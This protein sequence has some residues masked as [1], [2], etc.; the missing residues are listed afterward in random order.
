MSVRR[1]EVAVV[2]GGLV[3]AS[4]ALATARLGLDT[5][6]VEAVP[7]RAESQPSYD[8]RTLALNRASCCILEGLGLWP[9]LSPS[10]TPIRRVIVR[11]PGRPGR[12]VLDPADIGLDRFG[13]VVEARVF[14]QA[15]LAALEEAG[16]VEVRCPV[17]VTGVTLRDD[18]ARIE[19][20]GSDET[21][22]I[23]ARLLVAADGANS[24]VRGALGIQAREHDYGQS[25]VICNLTPTE[26]HRGRAWELLTSDGPFAVLPH[27]GDRCG[28]VW[29][30]PSDAAETLET[31]PEDQFIERAQ[32][33]FGDDLGSFQ[34]I[35]QRSRYPLREVR[36]LTDTAPR[37]VVLGNA[38][39]TMHPI[40]AQG[41]N[42]GLR[43][44]ATLAELLAERGTDDPGDAG[45]LQRYSAW[46]EPDQAGT[47][48]YADG[49]A[50]AWSNPTALMG[51]AR[52]A[53]FVAHALLP[54]LRR[55]LVLRAMGYRGRVPRLAMGEPLT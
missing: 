43:D 7:F 54:P 13:H 44:V 40:G 45:V 32:A 28:L 4:L 6:L 1:C 8:D 5:V 53:G 37:T 31:L 52:D 24:F 2:G 22:V 23:E 55:Q 46:R 50:R 27:V 25:A 3:G 10:A 39:H 42:L 14:G 18:A 15:A 17:K 11:N 30:A 41:F 12:V 34:R 38:A 16:T 48:A 47:M 19:L 26:P 29:T 51:I 9:G 33:R 36:A 20:D 35:G 49:L 21:A